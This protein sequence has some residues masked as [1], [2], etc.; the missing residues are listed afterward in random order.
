MTKCWIYKAKDGY[1][2]RLVAAN[3]RIIAESG[4]AY[5]TWWNAKK[6]W[7]GMAECV[8]LGVTVEVHKSNG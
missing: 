3:G 4:E 2:W 8:I 5:S 7:H 1:R 6:A